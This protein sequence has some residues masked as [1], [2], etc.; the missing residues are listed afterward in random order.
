MYLGL[1][2]VG[3]AVV[4]W[5]I[6]GTQGGVFGIIGERLTTRL[7]VHL[8]RAILRQAGRT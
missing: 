6:T 8:F 7:R 5:I 2:F 4:G 3:I 1:I